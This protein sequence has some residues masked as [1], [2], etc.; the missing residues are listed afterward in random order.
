MTLSD[1]SRD[2]HIEALRRVTDCPSLRRV[3]WLPGDPFVTVAKRHPAPFWREPKT[4][5]RELYSPH[6]A[7]EVGGG[8]H[9]YFV[10]VVVRGEGTSNPTY[11]YDAMTR[12]L[13]EAVRSTAL[14]ARSSDTGE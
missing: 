9:S 11:D 3:E 10:P 4:T 2:F 12:N 14:K 8:R 13:V 7:W 5:E 1:L 6:F